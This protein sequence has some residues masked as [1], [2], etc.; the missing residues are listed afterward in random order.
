MLYLFQ[1]DDALR[2]TCVSIGL[3]RTIEELLNAI[4]GEFGICANEAMNLI[5]SLHHPHDRT[6]NRSTS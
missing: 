6:A 5:I 4:H 1:E 3:I 2:D